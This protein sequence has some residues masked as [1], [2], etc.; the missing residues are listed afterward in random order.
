LTIRYNAA[1]QFESGTAGK[2][3]PDAVLAQLPASSEYDDDTVVSAVQPGKTSIPVTGGTWSFSGYDADRKT[4]SGADAVFIGKWIFTAN[5]PTPSGGGSVVKPGFTRYQAGY[6]FVSG[7]TGQ[8]LPAEV[9]A[10][11]PA[12]TQQDDGDIV[13]AAQPAKTSVAFADG[14]WTFQGY[15]ANTKTIRNADILFTGTWIYKAES[16]VS[17]SS[18]GTSST[19]ASSTSATVSGAP[20][21]SG[22]TGTT[23]VP[24]TGDERELLMYLTFLLLSAFCFGGT[25]VLRKR[26][27]KRSCR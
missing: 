13:T 20:A 9:T 23:T 3:L 2:T 12:A 21:S 7:T 4:I 5:T 19:T 27:E 22:S 11:L 25:F 26:T 10:L 18:A 8:T 17:S 6:A 1:Y 15:D 24:Q 16:S 14:T